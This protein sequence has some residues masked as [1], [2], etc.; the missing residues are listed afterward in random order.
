[1]LEPPLGR[2]SLAI[3]LCGDK[4]G[5]AKRFR[6]GDLIDQRQSRLQISPPH[7]VVAD[8]RGSTRSPQH[9]RARS[10]LALRGTKPFDRTCA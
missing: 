5:A 2:L 9:T 8:E 6:R 10:S 4:V 1:M 7:G 3:D